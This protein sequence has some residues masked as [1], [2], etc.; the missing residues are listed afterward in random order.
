MK[1]DL[2]AEMLRR[3]FGDAM[4]TQALEIA[5]LRRASAVD[6]LR[7]LDYRTT[8]VSKAAAGA[9][10]RLKVEKPARDVQKDRIFIATWPCWPA[11]ERSYAALSLRVSSGGTASRPGSRQG[12]R[13]ASVAGPRAA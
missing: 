10:A 9:R 5:D 11:S 7:L 2:T 3:R 1:V 8:C 12:P 4:L 6:T 13:P